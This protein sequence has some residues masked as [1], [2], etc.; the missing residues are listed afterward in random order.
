MRRH[1]KKDERTVSRTGGV[2]L[3]R[4]D[5]ET[6]CCLPRPKDR[7]EATLLFQTTASNELIRSFRRIILLKRMLF[8]QIVAASS[9]P[10][11]IDT[12]EAT[13]S[14]VG[15]WKSVTCQS[16]EFG[17]FRRHN[18]PLRVSLDSS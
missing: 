1:I 13:N 6:S 4:Y 10:A 17:S 2:K 18:L 15:N 8:I 5:M 7:D 9:N 12:V 3:D 16:W 11:D 14:R